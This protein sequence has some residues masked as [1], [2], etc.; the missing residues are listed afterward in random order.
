MKINKTIAGIL[1]YITYIF[2]SFE[3]FKVLNK[4]G[5]I[6]K[7][8]SNDTKFYIGSIAFSF[9]FASLVLVTQY[10]LWKIV[11][12]ILGKVE[13][14][15]NFMTGIMLCDAGIIA[16]L[17]LMTTVTGKILI[18]I[19]MLSGFN[20]IIVAI[21]LFYLMKEKLNKKQLIIVCIMKVIL[22]FVYFIAFVK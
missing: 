22:Y 21:L 2:F 12:D 10:F 3:L 20:P 1:Y 8:F 6:E 7:I 9:L 14:E 4:N 16:T 19:G 17:L 18:Y 11:L 5:D 13:K 15:E